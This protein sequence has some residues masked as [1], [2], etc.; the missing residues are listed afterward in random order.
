[1]AG[2]ARELVIAGAGCAGLSL[3]VH[4]L[5]A[6]VTDRRITV[7]DP[8]QSFARD[9]TWCFWRQEP[10]PFEA[11]IGHSWSRW[12]VSSERRRSVAGSSRHPYQCLAA[13]DFYASALEQLERAP[14]VDLQLGVRVT[15]ARQ[16]GD[17]VRIETDRG[18]LRGAYLFDSRPPPAA[19]GLVQRFH[20]LFVRSA[21]P[22]FDPTTVELMDFRFG[23]PPEGLPPD[24][25]RFFYLLPFSATE[26]LVE[27]T[28]FCPASKDPAPEK[29]VADSSGLIHDYLARQ[30]GRRGEDRLE[31]EVLSEERGAIPMSTAL[32][33][34]P[35]PASRLVPI[36]LRGGH[37]RASSGYAFLAI[38]DTARQ[39]AAAVEAGES[40]AR[41]APWRGRARFLDRV[42]LSFLEKD[43]ERAAEAFEGLFRR[44]PAGG[45]VRFLADRDRP[46][47][48][49]RVVSALPKLPLLGA[50]VRGAQPASP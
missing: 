49:L 16:E 7:L 28:Y 32:T 14:N 22:V 45:L 25:I 42:F 9:R 41:I 15:A 13:D 35:D 43:P 38:Q 19:P 26:A 10:H 3:A 40:P 34:A 18:E 6:G 12:A 5:R 20:G 23:P 2:E 36:G 44:V 27:A 39:L 37:A 11:A 33:G 46:A 4:L 17:R 29:T 30:F 48:A 31:L 47:D 1:M 50:L 24:V 21:V 8:R